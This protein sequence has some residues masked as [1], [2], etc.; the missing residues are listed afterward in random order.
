MYEI[1][2][3]VNGEPKTAKFLENVKFSDILQA[4]YVGTNMCFDENGYY[5]PALLDFSIGYAV[6]SALT[7]VQLGTDPDEAYPVIKDIGVLKT[8]D[9]EYI[10]LAVRRAVQYKND[11]SLSAMQSYGTVTLTEQ[12][13]ATLEK[14]NVALDSMVHF[15]DKSEAG[16]GSTDLSDVIKAISCG[17]LSG[18]EMIAHILAARNTANPPAENTQI[19][20][21]T[22]KAPP[23][24]KKPTARK[25]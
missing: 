4:I 12:I 2:Y 14:A 6:I 8:A 18:K 24:A 21:P 9:A 1:H 22:V 17:N 15:L 5:Q 19:G 3:T 10:S 11:E 16:A 7:D 13:G 23:T 25:K 20:H